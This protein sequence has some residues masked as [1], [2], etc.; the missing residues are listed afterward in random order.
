MEFFVSCITWIICNLLTCLAVERHLGR[1][2]FSVIITNAVVNIL[3]CIWWVSVH[4]CV[5]YSAPGNGIADSQFQRFP[6]GCI[7]SHF[8]QQCLRGPVAPRPHQH[9][10]LSVVFIFTPCGVCVVVSHGGFHFPNECGHLVIHTYF[11]LVILGVTYLLKPVPVLFLQTV[12]LF[13]NDLW[14]LVTYLRHK[15]FVR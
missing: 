2:H 13:L 1:F 8:H 12:C 6:S 7:N 4:T 15:S 14:E 11:N 5:G 3:V 10:V 9:L